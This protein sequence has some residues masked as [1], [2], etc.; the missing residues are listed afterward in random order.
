MNTE[1]PPPGDC[2]KPPFG[3]IRAETRDLKQLVKLAVRRR[4]WRSAGTRPNPLLLLGPK[5]PILPMVVVE[6]RNLTHRDKLMWLNLRLRLEDTGKDRTLPSI[7]ELAESTDLGNK[8][9]VARSMAMLRCRRYLSVCA[10]AWHGGGRKVGTAYALHAPRLPMKEVLFLDPEY[11]GFVRNLRDHSE[12]RLRNAAGDE[13]IKLS[14]C[15]SEECPGVSP[16]RQSQ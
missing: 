5:V 1:H 9:T 13:F 14:A 2:G 6:D 11:P 16:A 15:E 7:R 8:D 3:G 12:E 4:K 10:T